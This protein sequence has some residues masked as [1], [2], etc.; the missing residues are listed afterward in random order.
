MVE[1]NQHQ[2]FALKKLIATNLKD[3]KALEH[4]YQILLDIQ[5]H[6]KKLI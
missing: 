1:N 6:G 2:Y 5:S 3:I 4:E